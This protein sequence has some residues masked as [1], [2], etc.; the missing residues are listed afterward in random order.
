MLWDDEYLYIG[1]ELTSDFAVVAKA[2]ERNAVIYHT[3]SDFE[4][5]I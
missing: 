3:D 2:V 4:V 5:Y 1:A